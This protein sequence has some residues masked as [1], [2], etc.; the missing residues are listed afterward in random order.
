MN[1]SRTYLIVGANN[2]LSLRLTENLPSKNTFV[3][4]NS[5]PTFK[6]EG[7]TYYGIDDLNKLP[8]ID[9]VF[10]ISAF[11][12]DRMD[13]FNDNLELFNVNI[14]FI[15]KISDCFKDSKLIYASSVS[16]YK[17]IPGKAI[18]EDSEIDPLSPYAISKLW[19]EKIIKQTSS[20]SI[21]RISSLIGSGIKERTF[22][23]IVINEA[24]NNK[25]ITLYGNGSRVQ[26]YINY[27]DVCKLLIKASEIK[28]NGTYLAVNPLSISN[29]GVAELIKE[30]IPDV[31]IKYIG[32]DAS[33]SFR[34]NAERTYADLSYTPSITI[35][36]SINEILKW[37]TEQF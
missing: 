13:S 27:L 6:K 36:E 33:S 28:T 7:V 4:Y 25:T 32:S 12:P 20:Y 15:K 19:A 17:N 8:K 31:S 24:F 1:S 18:S 16:I 22:V 37:K 3:L 26:N 14:Q 23:P 9:V 29:T 10:I 5:A 34:Y 30:L 21:F 2:P 35:K 11:V